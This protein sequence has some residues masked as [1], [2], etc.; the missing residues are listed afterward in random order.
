[1]KYLPLLLVAVLT[2][3]TTV[4]V[5]MTFPEAPTDSEVCPADL[6]RV[7]EQPKL[8]DVSKVVVKNYGAYHECAVK[9]ETW[10]EW[11]TKQ[12]KIFESVK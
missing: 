8:S 4:P 3:C 2:G 12:K 1:M 7:P 10:N 6:D 5:V 11:Y 9:V